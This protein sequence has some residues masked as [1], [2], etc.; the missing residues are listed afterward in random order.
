MN[1]LQSYMLD[2]SYVYYSGSEIYG[3]GWYI[4]EIDWKVSDSQLFSLCS[5]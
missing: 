2:R 4:I 3:V 5:Y 1:L